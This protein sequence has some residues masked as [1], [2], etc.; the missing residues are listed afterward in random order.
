[1]QNGY[2]EEANT[3]RQGVDVKRLGWAQ[4]ALIQLVCVPNEL[5]RLDLLTKHAKNLSR[6]MELASQLKLAH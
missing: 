4:L 1:M 6:L 2:L 3:R 5:A